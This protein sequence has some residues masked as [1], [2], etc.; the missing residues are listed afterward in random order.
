MKRKKSPAVDSPQ[1]QVSAGATPASTPKRL[2]VSLGGRNKSKVVKI[3]TTNPPGNPAWQKG[4]SGNPSGRPKGSRHKLS[5]SFISALHSDFEANGIG[6]IAQVR[7]ESPGEYLRVISS[8]VPK[9]FGIEEGTQNAF[10][11][12]WRAISEGRA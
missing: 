11:E 10:I 12:V 4:I 5:E 1:P 6:A 9:Q 2:P 3:E 7:R 8:I